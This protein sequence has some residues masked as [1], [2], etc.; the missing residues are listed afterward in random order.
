[1]IVSTYEIRCSTYSNVTRSYD[2]AVTNLSA[3]HYYFRL[4]VHAPQKDFHA[5]VHADAV[6]PDQSNQFL[7]LE[8]AGPRRFRTKYLAQIASLQTL[9]FRF[10]PT[11]AFEWGAG[12]FS[13]DALGHVELV[14]P[15]L[16]E[17]WSDTHTSQGVDPVPVL[18]HPF[19]HDFHVSTLERD[20]HPIA[21]ASGQSRNEIVPDT[22]YRFGFADATLAG[23]TQQMATRSQE[24]ADALGDENVALAQTLA[25]LDAARRDAKSLRAL[26]SLIGEAGL[27]FELKE[28]Q[29]GRGK[30]RR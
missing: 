24:V 17:S 29:K 23:V 3:E 10:F 13:F 18:V 6:G 15:T 11:G 26:N 1:V 21:I 9:R 22:P 19:Q 27:P 30:K 2:L 25:V 12:P 20:F 14:I 7:A 8:P 4:L 5:K 16:Y 28:T